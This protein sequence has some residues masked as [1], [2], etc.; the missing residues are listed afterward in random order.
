MASKSYKSFIRHGPDKWIPA[1]CGFMLFMFYLVFCSRDRG[2]LRICKF[3]KKALCKSHAG[4]R[5]KCMT[6]SFIFLIRSPLF[7]FFILFF[8]IPET[9]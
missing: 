8:T 7:Y 4:R 2:V 3:H 5:L 1:L 9:L 6:F